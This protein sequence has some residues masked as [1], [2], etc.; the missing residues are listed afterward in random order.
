MART[1]A[2]D[3]EKL[4]PAGLKCQVPPPMVN[5]NSARIAP[6]SLSWRLTRFFALPMQ[7]SSSVLGAGTCGTSRKKARRVE[8][9]G[10]EDTRGGRPDRSSGEWAFGKATWSPQFGDGG[11]DIYRLMREVR[12]D[13]I[14]LHFVDN[15]RLHLEREF[16]ELRLTP[17][18]RAL[19]RPGRPGRIDLRYVSS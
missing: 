8:D 14:V 10:R 16:Q 7:T 3:E 12:R 6:D 13:D 18:P 9:M 1:A 4:G 19:L 17:T 2:K 11:R 5:P 15:K